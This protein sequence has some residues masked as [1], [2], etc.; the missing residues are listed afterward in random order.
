MEELF[1]LVIDELARLGVRDLPG[2]VVLTG[3]VAKLEGIAQ[4]ARQILQ[5]RVRIYTPD[6]IGV[7]EPSFTTAVGLIRYAYLEDDFMEKYKYAAYRICSCR[8][9]CSH[10]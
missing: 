7:R 5:T 1:E 3:G 9:P 8:I 10:T 2:G 6:Y 4:L